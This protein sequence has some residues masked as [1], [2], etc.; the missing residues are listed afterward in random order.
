MIAFYIGIIVLI[1][2]YYIIKSDIDDTKGFIIGT[3][4]YTPERIIKIEKIFL[5]DPSTSNR[6]TEKNW[7]RSI[8]LVKPIDDNKEGKWKKDDIL[9]FRKYIGQ[10]IKKKYIILQNRRKEKR[11]A[12][13]TAE[14]PGFPP[15]FDGPETLIEYE[16]IGVLESFYTPQKSYN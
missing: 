9:I 4:Q 5:Y 13:C 16:I 3:S 12:Y 1:V 8:I 7:D 6:K 14:S 2:L 11:I 15:I 10:S